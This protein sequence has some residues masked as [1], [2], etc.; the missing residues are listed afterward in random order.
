MTLAATTKST[1]GLNSVLAKKG[2]TSKSAIANFNGSLSA[3]ICFR[4]ANAT[5]H[6]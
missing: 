2:S 3:Q 1:P 4:P 6:G 5:E